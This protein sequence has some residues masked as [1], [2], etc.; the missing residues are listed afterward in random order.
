MDLSK[1]NYSYD[2]DTDSLYIYVSEI[3]FM[4]SL[5]S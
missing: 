2:D 1:I 5:L 4:M 3:M